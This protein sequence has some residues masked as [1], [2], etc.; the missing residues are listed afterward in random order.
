M[1]VLNSCTK[2]KSITLA[3]DFDDFYLGEDEFDGLDGDKILTVLNQTLP[4]K[5][6][7]IIC[8]CGV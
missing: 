2:L 7:S 5:L 4:K 3:N 8:T 1:E 6:G